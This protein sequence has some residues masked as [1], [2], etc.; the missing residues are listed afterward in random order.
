MPAD[1][2]PGCQRPKIVGD[3]SNPGARSWSMVRD[4]EGYRTYIVRHRVHVNVTDGPYNALY[5]TPGLPS[6]GSMWD[7]D[8]DQDEW[9]YCTQEARV[10]PV[11][12]EG[13]PNEFFD[14]EQVFSTKPA[15]LC[16]DDEGGFDDPLLRADIITGGFNKYTI[17]ARID[18]HGDPIVNSAWEQMRGPQ[19]EFDENR[20]KI[21]IRQNVADLE[22]DVLCQHIDTVNDA[23][24]WGFEARC[25]KFSGCSWEKHYHVDCTVYYT[26]ELEFDIKYDSFDRDLIDEGTKVLPGHWDPITGAYVLDLAA[27]VQL[28]TTQTAGSNILTTADSV[29]QLRT[30]MK[31]EG[32]GI[33]TGTTVTVIAVGSITLSANATA[34]R[35][36]KTKFGYD[37]DPNNPQHFVR[38]KDRNNENTRVILNGAGVPWDPAGVTDTATDD[39]MGTIPV[40]YYGETDFQTALGLPDT[41]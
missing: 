33:P 14:I 20:P 12:P 27:V 24:M 21:R 39:V 13:E 22:F 34:D 36:G 10:D 5:N 38:F 23:P 17:E 16:P 9:A 31:V 41:F 1:I 8:D 4:A 29:A 19:V 37:G 30:G 28:T 6:P 35:E 3:P 2:L 15:V 11:A 32:T 26:R 40:E 18:S 7:I 25:V